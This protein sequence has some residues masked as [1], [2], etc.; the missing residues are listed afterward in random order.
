M[1]SFK[2]PSRNR[3]REDEDPLKTTCTYCRHTQ[4]VTDDNKE[5]LF[6][7]TKTY[8]CEKCGEQYMVGLKDIEYKYS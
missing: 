5:K 2:F 3:V 4:D 7:N 8:W 1:K 6:T